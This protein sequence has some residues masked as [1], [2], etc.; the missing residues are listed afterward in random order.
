MTLVVAAATNFV[1]YKDVSADPAAR[2]DAAMQAAV[3]EAL[4]ARCARTTS[5]STSGSSAARR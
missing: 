5:P 1:S 2:V 4:R 3:G